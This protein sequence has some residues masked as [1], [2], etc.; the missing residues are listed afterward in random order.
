[1]S[2]QDDLNTSIQVNVPDQI[3][4][5]AQYAQSDEIQGVPPGLIATPIQKSDDFFLSLGGKPVEGVPP[6]LIEE[7]IRDDAFFEKLGGRIVGQPVKQTQLSQQELEQRAYENAGGTS[8]GD[9]TK[10]ILGH[11]NE[12]AS[13]GLG[14]S[15]PEM[16]N[17]IKDTVKKHFGPNATDDVVTSVT[18]WIGD[19]IDEQYGPHGAVS[20]YS[21]D[22]DLGKRAIAAIPMMGPALAGVIKN[23]ENKEYSEAALTT[24][25]V[26]VQMGVMAGL[27]AEGTPGVA[28]RWKSIPAK[29]TFL[30]KVWRWIADLFR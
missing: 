20:K 8:V 28:V 27:S 26:G 1:M 2:E 7:P 14:R 16:W 15:A 29:L 30:Q 19:Q 13:Q 9:T 6:G 22:T 18:N 5:P 11:I 3:Q 12:A 21:P 24:G 4:R 25:K 23:L 10:E 17:N